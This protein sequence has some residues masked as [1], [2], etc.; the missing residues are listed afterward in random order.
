MLVSGEFCKIFRN[1]YSLEHLP[2]AALNLSA[3]QFTTHHVEKVTSLLLTFRILIFFVTLEII[4]VLILYVL[5]KRN[6]NMKVLKVTRL[7]LTKWFCTLYLLHLQLHVL[8]SCHSWF[9]SQQRN[10]VCACLESNYAANTLSEPTWYEISLSKP[11]IF[12]Y[13]YN[14]IFPCVRWDC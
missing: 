7:L 4:R 8:I 6:R 3:L 13:F 14:D 10:W 11:I 12:W 2:T 9:W 1:N 5:K